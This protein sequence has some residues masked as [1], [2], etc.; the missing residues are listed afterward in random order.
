M[1][2]PGRQLSAE[3]SGGNWRLLQPFATLGNNRKIEEVLGELT[4]L[5][6]AGG[7][8]GFVADN[9]SD[10]TPYGLDKEHGVRIALR[11]V[12]SQLKPQVIVVGK[13]VP[14]QEGKFYAVQEGQDDV[15][16]IGGLGQELSTLG[17]DPNALRSTK[18]ADFETCAGLLHSDR[19]AGTNLRHGPHG[20]R[21]ED[22]PSRQRP[23][24]SRVG[25]DSP[26]QAR[27]ARNE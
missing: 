7:D 11:P 10:L 2:G 24:G 6:V 3:R 13:P 8:A 23:G 4:S 21:L 19:A 20:P 14:N 16:A 25:D 27:I 15:V 22:R 5:R 1:T 18:V 17:T 12:L 9:V 26:L